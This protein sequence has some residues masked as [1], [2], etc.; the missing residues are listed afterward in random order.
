MG[1]E[2]S[3]EL[4]PTNKYLRQKVEEQK[5]TQQAKPASAIP[6]VKA[7]PKPKLP[8]SPNVVLII[9][10]DQAWTDYSFLA[11]PVIKTPRID[12]LARESATFT[13]GYVPQALCR[14]SLATLVSGLYPRHHKI[15]GNDPTPWGRALSRELIRN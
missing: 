6:A 12:Q 13:R 2:Y 1:G 4:I 15:T 11:H 10:D 3:Y 8:E 9:S 5:K 7:R 14:S